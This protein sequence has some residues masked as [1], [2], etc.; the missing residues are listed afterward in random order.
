MQ[1]TSLAIQEFGKGAGQELQ[2]RLVD[3]IRHPWIE[4]WQYDLHVRG[5]YLKRGD[6][7]H[8]HGTFY[9]GHLLTEKPQ[10]QAERAAI[11]SAAANH[12]KQQL[13]NGKLK[14]EHM[15]E[16]P[17]CL[18]SLKWLFNANREPCVGVDTMQRYPANEYLVAMR[19]GHFSKIMLRD[20]R[21]AT[22]YSV[23]QAKFQAILNESA[24]GALAVVALSSRERDKWAKLRQEVGAIDPINNALVSMIESAAFVICLDEGSPATPTER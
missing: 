2:K 24:E 13:D 17:I 15:N 12:F 21:T 9:S 11:M 7:G 4:N 3:R 22:F 20:G 8:P 16:E 10:I 5:I 14:P 1:N 23:L 19:R 18:D 6:P